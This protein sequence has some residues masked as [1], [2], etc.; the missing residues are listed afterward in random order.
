MG[1][2]GPAIS[3]ND[4]YKDI[5]DDFMDLY[6]E[7]LESAE[8]SKKVIKKN[9]EL[10][11]SHEDK[12]NFW[13]A[14]AMAQWQCK[15]L[16]PD[17]YQRVKQIVKT[18]EDI[19]L[20]KDLGAESK[21]LQKREKALNSFLEK[22]S[23]E[24]EKARKRKKK[25]LRD[26]I[27]QRGDCLTFKLENENYGGAFVLTSEEKTEYGMNMIAITTLNLE[28]KPRVDE[29]KSASILIT[30]QEVYQYLGPEMIFWHCAKHFKK[31]PI[32]FEVIGH[33]KV[34]R[35]YKF[36]SHYTRVAPWDAIKIMVDTHMHL[37]TA[38]IGA[39][40]G[41]KLNKL[42]KRSWFWR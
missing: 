32:N 33:L 14:L 8:I 7:G 12:N 5:Y 13:F 37:I 19:R 21:A 38:G 11:N 34:S 17:L 42:R 3:S 23:T 6:D 31:A 40:K 29:F 24:K 10:I 35:K 26:S 1:S 9:S 28:E 27:F 41:V 30:D 2:W 20:W 18:G 39:K 16:E 25:V 4:I 15:A 22:L 36:D